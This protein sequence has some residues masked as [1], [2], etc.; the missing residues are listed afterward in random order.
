M[1]ASGM[2]CVPWQ[3]A[4]FR[5]LSPPL[6]VEVDAASYYYRCMRP[7]RAAGSWRASGP[8][9]IFSVFLRVGPG[10]GVSAA[11]VERSCDCP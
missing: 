10:G 1:E 5:R 3:A 2:S 11:G 9:S 6:L 4:G 8:D 7:Q